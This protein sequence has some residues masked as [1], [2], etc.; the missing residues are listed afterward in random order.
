MELPFAPGV[1]AALFPLVAARIAGILFTAPLFSGPGIP[2]LAKGSIAL[3]T[4]VAVMPAVSAAGFSLPQAQSAY[5]LSLA[6][7]ALA[8]AATGFFLT[9]LFSSLSLASGYLE[10]VSGFA[11]ASI[12]DP[13]TGRE[14]PALSGIFNIAAISV[15]LSTKGFQ[16]LFLAGIMDSFTRFRIDDL[17]SRRDSLFASL[18]GAAGRL[19]STAFSLALPILGC[20]LLFWILS[21]IL[22]RTAA[23]FNFFAG[24]FTIAALVF[25]A[26]LAF[27]LPP[28]LDSFASVL[29]SAYSAL[30]VFLRGAP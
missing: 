22:S 11:S 5:F 4:A 30:R 6:A 15:F 2:V 24:E 25:C 8:G 29:D 12:L 13:S 17:A 9:L 27:A 3:L 19:F 1:D 28:I 20:L 26:A 21:G 18:V 10:P 16:R 7:E 14:S 23:S